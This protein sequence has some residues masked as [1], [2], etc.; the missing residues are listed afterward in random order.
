MFRLLCKNEMKQP[1]NQQLLKCI[2][3]KAINYKYYQSAIIIQSFI[4]MK[5]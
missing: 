4:K 2:I 3:G 1:T 5:F